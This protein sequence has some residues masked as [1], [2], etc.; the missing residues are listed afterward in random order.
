MAVPSLF[1]RS[2]FAAPWR[3]LDEIENRMSRLFREP[4]FPAED[5]GWAPAVEVVEN[6]RELRLTAELPGVDPEDVEIELEQNV[7]TIRGEKNEEK[8]E[9]K[10]EGERKYRIW[11]RS[12]G[13]FSRSFTLPSTVD[14]EKIEAK[15]DQGVLTVHLPKTREATGRRIPVESARK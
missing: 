13:E 7:L 12:Y 10:E 1:R 5:M 14:A 4:T 3:E 11:E 8:E 15:F 6:D 2:G 9:E